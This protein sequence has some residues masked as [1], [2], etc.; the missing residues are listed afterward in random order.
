MSSS[1][2]NVDQPLGD[3]QGCPRLTPVSF[4]QRVSAGRKPRQSWP[5]LCDQNHKSI[6]FSCQCVT[7]EQSLQRDGRDM[8]Y[9][10]GDFVDVATFSREANQEPHSH[11]LLPYIFFFVET[12]LHFSSFKCVPLH[13]G[14]SREQSSILL[15]KP[16][17]PKC[18][19]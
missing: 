4:T 2:R 19:I 10:H 11:N 13:S 16:P 15:G 7:V 1:H 18:G 14:Q 8:G 17:A 3:W 6:H 5:R 9:R 12:V